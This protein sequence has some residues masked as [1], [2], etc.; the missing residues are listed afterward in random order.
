MKSGELLGPLETE[1]AVQ[2]GIDANGHL[3]HVWWGLLLEAGRQQAAESFGLN[4][5]MP[6]GRLCINYDW[7]IFSGDHLT[8]WTYASDQKDSLAFS[9]NI[10]KSDIK[11]GS[12][13]ADYKNISA[14]QPELSC[15]VSVMNVKLEEVFP[16]SGA[17]LHHLTA[18]F[19]FEQARKELFNSK[20]KNL[21][22]LNIQ[23]RI[24]FVVAILNVDYFLPML[25]DQ[26]VSI[27]SVL[28]V[29]DSLF[30]FQQDMAAGK[31]V[32]NSGRITCAIIDREDQLI[33]D[34]KIIEPIAEKLLS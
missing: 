6:L 19:Y 25:R 22:E 10:K 26:S 20:G 13:F 24:R 4:V 33:Q 34:P 31:T 11:V 14:A 18:P 27:R 28:D 23:D 2:K 30:I 7:Q 8:I 17:E 16:S 12:S 9:Q 21:R 5:N 15:P 3:N 32:L 29:D 1:A